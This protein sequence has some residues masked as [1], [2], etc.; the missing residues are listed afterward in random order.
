[1]EP[2][3]GDPRVAAQSIFGSESQN[4]HGMAVVGQQPRGHEAVAP[5]VAG[6]GHDRDRAAPPRPLG[7]RIRHRSPGVLHQLD[8]GRA[9]RDRQPVGLRHFLV[10]QELDHRG[11]TLPVA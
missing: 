1:M 10:V 9:A 7:N 8:A 3:R 5:I 2:L 11:G 6:A 4:A